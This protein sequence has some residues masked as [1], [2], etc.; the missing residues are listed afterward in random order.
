MINVTFYKD[1]SHDYKGFKFCGH[2]GYAESGKDIVCAAVSVLVINFINS[3]EALTDDKFNLKQDENKGLI[4]FDFSGDISNES[5][6]L[7]NSLV[8][9]ISEIQKENK[10]YIQ[11]IF[12]E[13]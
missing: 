2:A 13:V 10:K 3:V 4:D 7:M 5:K 9:G 8:L 11:I 1:S 6:V 12:K